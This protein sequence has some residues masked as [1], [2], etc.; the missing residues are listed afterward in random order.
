MIRNTKT[1]FKHFDYLHTD[2][3]GAYLTAMSRKGWHFR[4]W[5]VGLIFERGEPADIT[6]AVEIFTDASEYDT[7]PEV[8]TK[9]FAEY[10][11]AAGWKLMDAKRKFCIFKKVR[12][13]AV[14]ILTDE[15][16]LNN[17]AKE[18]GKILLRQLVLALWF[19]I[20]QN[21]S[22][23][24]NGFVN[25]IFANDYLFTLLLWDVLA[26]GVLAKVTAF[27]VW[28]RKQ[29]NR[30]VQGK[31]AHFGKSQGMVS[32]FQ[33]VNFWVPFIICGGYGA[34]C[35]ATEQYQQLVLMAVM[36]IPLML[37][38]YLIDRF[39]PDAVTNQILQ[40]VVPCLVMI[41][42]LSVVVGVTFSGNGESADIEDVPLLYE[43][44]GG[45]AGEL[46][47]ITL[48]G[49]TSIFGSGL[50]CW[51][52]YEEESVNYQVYKSDH[53]WVL[54]KICNDMEKSYHYNGTDVADIWNTVF[55]KQYENGYYLVRYPEAVLIFGVA[56]DTVLSPKQ[57]EIIRSALLESR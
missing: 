24:G 13:D 10:C 48:D 8:N 37:M 50:R 51:L 23:F 30:I 42:A 9:E 28:K 27:L 18:E 6:Y 7:R 43:D 41:L 53:S 22:F 56:E 38:C 14:E 49:S 47:D 20:W 33:S 2:D 16:R 44:I 19:C 45:A 15:E 3:F 34:Y 5:R 32:F 4:E 36:L 1:V 40:I 29:H 46:E 25:H 21:Y 12:E 57:A 54:D 17:V 52:Y 55:A 26:I 39:R 35:T 31:K 11:E